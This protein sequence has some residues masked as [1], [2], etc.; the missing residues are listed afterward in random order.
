MATMAHITLSEFESLVRSVK[1]PSE[2][3]STVT[4]EDDRAAVEIVKRKRA[5]EAMQELRGSGNGNL[6]HALLRERER[7]QTL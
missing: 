6:V 7:D 2:T 3:R 4:V 5:L 1:L